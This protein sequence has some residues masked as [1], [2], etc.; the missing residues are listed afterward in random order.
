ML[1]RPL[2][3]PITS[4]ALVI[5]RANDSPYVTTSFWR[6][7]LVASPEL[8]FAPAKPAG[9]SEPPAPLPPSPVPPL[10]PQATANPVASTTQGIQPRA[11][12]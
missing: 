2:T 11:T 4:A 7:P 9:A 10:P 3:S 8:P 5:A 1:A 6:L 12:A